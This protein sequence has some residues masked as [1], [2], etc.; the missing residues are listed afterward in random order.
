MKLSFSY[1]SY[2]VDRFLHDP[3]LLEQAKVK[4]IRVALLEEPRR[5]ET[6]I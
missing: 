5:T 1:S 3:P 6:S 4:E 2:V